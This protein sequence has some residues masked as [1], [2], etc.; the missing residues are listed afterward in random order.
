MDA[1]A[2]VPAPVNEP[3]HDYAPGSGERAALEHR[4][5]EFAGEGAVELPH[6]VAGREVLGEGK[7]LDVVQPH[8]RRSVLG[9]LRNATTDDARTAVDAA[10]A[11]GSA[12]R[13]LPFEERAAVFLKAAELLSGPWRCTLNAATMLGQSKTAYQAEIDSACELIDFWRFNV[14]FAQEV[15]SAQPV[16]SPGVWN[17]S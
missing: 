1:V 17:R 9:T 16:S 8:A 12:W 5:A 3:I 11:A 13:A 2:R 7:P 10:L 6:T 4:L 15:V 14:H